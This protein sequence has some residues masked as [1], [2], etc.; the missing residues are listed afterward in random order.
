MTKTLF[1]GWENGY[2]VFGPLRIAGRFG[3]GKFL[4]MYLNSRMASLSE[5]EK[6]SVK[7]YMH[8]IFLRPASGEYALNV[9]L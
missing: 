8:Q 2:T 7:A 6:A 3:T 4:N 5:V 1:Y 9:V